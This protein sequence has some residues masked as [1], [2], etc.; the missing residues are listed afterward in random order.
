[1]STSAL[2]RRARNSPSP[3]VSAGEPQGSVRPAVALAFSLVGFFAIVIA[4]LGVVSLVTEE[5]VVAVPALGPAPGAIGLLAAG[6][7]YAAAWWV[8]ARTARP[9]F[10]WALVVAAASFLAYALAAGAAALV[11]AA[12]VGVAVAVAAGLAAGWPGLVVALG[13]LV[14]AWAGIALVRT[15]ASRPRWPWENDDDT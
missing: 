14:A 2:S 10:W 9:T 8:G 7:A 5:E 4:A 15:R 6:G 13:A 1:M 12:D 11:V 3:N